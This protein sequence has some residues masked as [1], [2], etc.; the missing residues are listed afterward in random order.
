V[1]DVV[2]LDA[3]YRQPAAV[4]MAPTLA[5]AER[6]T[7][8]KPLIRPD[9]Q[10]HLV[11]A[12]GRRLPET[13]SSAMVG[14]L[15]LPVIVRVH[16]QP[17]AVGEYWPG[18]DVTGA[19]KLARTIAGDIY[20]DQVKAIDAFARDSHGRVHLVLRTDL[21]SAT[22]AVWGPPPGEE[23]VYEPNAETKRHRLLA[24]LEQRG[25]VD[26]GGKLVLVNG[27]STSVPIER[28]N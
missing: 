23:M 15:G 14:R 10:F 2:K 8:G 13:Y 12:F 17:P 20:F 26:G 1:G 4:V 21:N 27:T 28:A 25:K 5:D 3:Q 6:L 9:D 18:E 24:V 7:R 22:G 16:E 11:D 19:L